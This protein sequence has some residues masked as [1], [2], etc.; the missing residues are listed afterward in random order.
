MKEYYIGL[1]IGTDSVGWAVTDTQYN[2]LKFKGNAMWGVRLFDESQTAQER[3]MFRASRRRNQRKRKRLDLLEMLFDKEI[4]AKDISFFKRLKESSLYYEDKDV[5]TPYAVF[6]D[7]NYTD[8]DYHKQY[9]TIYH[10]RAELIKNQREHDVRLV[11]LA[12]HHLIKNRGHFLFDNLSVTDIESFDKIFLELTTYLSDN[13]DISLSCEDSNKLSEVLKNRSLGKVKKTAQILE[14]SG[15]TKKSNPQ[16][17]AILSTLSG[18]SVKLADIF[19]D[20]TLKDIEVKSVSFSGKYEDSEAVLENI[21]AERFELIEKLKAIYDWAILEEIRRGEKYISFAKVKT[22]NEHH[23]D[24][25]ILKEYVKKYCPEKYNKIFRKTEAKLANYTAYCGKIKENGHNGVLEHKCNQEDFCAFL[26]RELPKIDDKRFSKMFE[27]IEASSFMPKQVNKDNGVIPMQINRAEVVA[28]LDNAKKYLPFLNECDENGISVYQKILDIF[29]FRI[30]YYVGPL[31]KHSENSWIVRKAGE[32]TPWNFKDIVD[33]DKSA[34]EFINKLTSKCTYLPDKDVIPK[35]SLLYSKFMVL[36]ELNNLKINGNKISVELKQSIYNDLFM[37][38]KRV[39]QKALSGYFKAKGYEDV[40]ITGVDGDFKAN[41]K[42][43]MDLTPYNL[44]DDEKED[45]INS[46]TIFG[47][48]KRLLR[49][50][51][52]ERYS[53][54]LTEDEILRISKLKYSGWSALS[55][56]FLTEIYG[57]KIATGEHFNLI[58]ALWETNDNL[59]ILLGSS[60][61]FAQAVE[62]ACENDVNT[63]LKK[64]VENLYVS[65]KVKRPIYQSLKI[66]KEIV[67]IMGCAPKKFFIEVAR[68]PEEKKRTVSRKAK[69]LEL[70][71][72]C[73]KESEELYNQLVETPENDFK[74]DKLFLYYTQFGKCMYT[75]ESISLDSLFDN[76]VYDIDH[77]FPRSKVKDDSLDNRVLVKKIVNAGK[78]NTYPLSSEI[79][80]KMYSHW[81]FLLDRELIS[82]K[83]FERLTRNYPLSDEELSDFISRQL[84]ETRQS[85]KAV[86]NILKSLYKEYGSEI[87]YSKASIVSEFRHDYDMLKCREVNDLHHAKDAY[88][89][90]VVG[91][92]YNERYTHNKANFIKGLQNK[93]YSLN[94]MFNYNVDNA[95]VADND[96]S[97]SIVKKYMN[98]NNILYTRYSYIQK[99]GLF[100]Q[101]PVKKGKGQVPLKLN[102]PKVDISKYGAYNR[103]SS[104]FFAFVEYTDNKG[105]NIRALVPVDSYRLSEYNN[106]PDIFMNNLLDAQNA[107]VLIKCIKYNSCLSFNGCRMHLSSKSGG[108][109]T[110]VYKPAVQLAVGY[111]WEKYIKDIAKLIKKDKDAE[112]TKYDGVTAEENI[113]L[114]DILTNKM[115]NTVMKFNLGSIGTKIANKREVF[116]E[117]TIWQQCFVISQ[118]LNIIHANVMT[119]DLKLIKEAGQAGASTTS[120]K[121]S[122][123]KSVQS[124]KLI[125]QSVT[126]LFETEVD[127]I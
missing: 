93:T 108:G 44:S 57:T 9:P 122:D 72:N 39:T 95:W 66:V 98:K 1:D 28:I 101:M 92:V 68:G 50:R 21:L 89:N 125:N 99:G 121:L 37:A 120:N 126:G 78:D 18:S 33:V 2:V 118:I 117:L 20:D 69:L 6:A 115:T 54:K 10:L 114:F 88:L 56:E 15:V 3:R 51:L 48:D 112:I 53:G 106:N 123:I 113:E 74:R 105:K 109:K 43:F 16:L 22:Y 73:K 67:K 30:P 100:D 61:N 85:T 4:S 81:K 34:E 102:S 52:K 36:N 75:G 64:M 38:K 116:S 83:K 13:Y 87:V 127:L 55:R 8:K 63:S 27:K 25:V 97:I 29:D 91:N 14:C 19:C 111:R 24:L 46:I 49:K 90:I 32:I 84:V 35:N 26:K 104:A 31:N 12:L 62:N 110:I 79:H 94:A 60:Y 47:D 124:L 11:F 96:E 59:M 77:I 119:G 17:A 107:K 42:P 45:I 103:P 82:K 70:Y 80:Q 71:K 40:E 58:T 65:P 5:D 41:L 23:D 86:A 7:K 76:N